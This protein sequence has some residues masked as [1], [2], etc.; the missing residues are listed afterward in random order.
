M[1]ENKEPKQISE[2][3]KEEL[4]NIT[5]LC[6]ELHYKYE[7]GVCLTE[8]EHKLFHSIYGRENNT[9]EQYKE[10]KQQYKQ[11]ISTTIESEI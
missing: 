9:I 2:Y 4:N 11:L 7:L 6:V 8:E 3:S 10:F 1:D 5:N